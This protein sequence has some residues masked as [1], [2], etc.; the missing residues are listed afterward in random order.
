VLDSQ[1]FV[2]EQVA[3]GE[4]E[5]AALARAAITDQ[6][7]LHFAAAHELAERYARRIAPVPSEVLRAYYKGG[8]PG[9][10]AGADAVQAQDWEGA[11][12]AWGQAARAA[13]GRERGKALWNLAVAA[14]QR[15]ELSLAL[16][17]ASRADT[18]LRSRQSARYV[19][20]LTRRIAAEKKLGRQLGG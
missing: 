13:E 9:I 4:G 6:N 3:V 16:D 14:E 10:R 5:T 11:S 20:D 1:E 12:K 17:Y 8:S 2:S 7:A 18:L 15:G 19:A